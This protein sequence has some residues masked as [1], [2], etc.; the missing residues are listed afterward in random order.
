MQPVLWS[1]RG[2]KTSN[3]V[4][5]KRIKSEWEYSPS[6]GDRDSA[7]SSV[8]V[9]WKKKGKMV[10]RDS[11]SSISGSTSAEALPYI[12][13]GGAAGQQRVR[14]SIRHLGELFFIFLLDG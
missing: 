4:S 5:V 10:F 8:A 3:N 9:A 11:R 6:S 2:K 13:G 12:R 1:N 14:L 7:T